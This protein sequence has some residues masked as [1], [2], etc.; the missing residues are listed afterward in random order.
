VPGG[1]RKLHAVS[2]RV[3]YADDNGGLLL[4]T[5]DAPL[6]APGEPSL[7]DFNDRQPQ[8]LRGMHFNLYNNVWG[9]NF[10]MWYD[11]DARFRF[12]LRVE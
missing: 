12:V 6:V 1:N 8:L 4:E 11:D 3:E 7:L 5:L 10:A 9:T 2:G